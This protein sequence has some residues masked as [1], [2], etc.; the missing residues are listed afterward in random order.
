MQLLLLGPPGAGK[1]TQA[2]LITE[3][4]QLLHLSTGDLLRKNIA[5]GTALGD[6]ARP[7]MES[8]KYVPDELVNKMVEAAIDDPAARN[9]VVFDGYPRT[10]NQA[11]TL[12]ALLENK[13]R[14][15][16]VVINLDVMPEVLIERLSGRRVCKGC[17]A[18]YHVKTMPSL[19]QGVCDQCGGELYQ[20][21]DDN[22]ETIR[23]RLKV[24]NQQ[25]E[26]LLNY[27]GQQRKLRNVDAAQGIER[28]SER[29]F[30]LLG[31]AA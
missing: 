22:E 6:E 23:T 17:G 30:E 25:T 7:Y 9:G 16:D 21:A 20:R 18:I 10:L 3:R 31:G 27:Y 13:G 1:G 28:T 2:K 19:T 29:V 14:P 15:I 8:G 4:Y 26:P 24:Y 5:N 11:E 12:D